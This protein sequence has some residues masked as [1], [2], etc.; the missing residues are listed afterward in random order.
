MTVLGFPCNQFGGQEPGTNAQ[1]LEFAK[2]RYDA[3]FQMFEKIEV[4]GGGACDLYRFLKGAGSQWWRGHR[5]ELHQVPGQRW[6]GGAG[7][8]RAPGHADTGRRGSRGAPVCNR[9]PFDPVGA[10]PRDRLT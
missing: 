7:A 6:R 5:V 1:I 8:L 10:N 2:S 3:N 9:W 4:N